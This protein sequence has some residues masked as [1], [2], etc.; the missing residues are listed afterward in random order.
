MLPQDRI[1]LPVELKLKPNYVLKKYTIVI[2]NCLGLGHVRNL[3][4]C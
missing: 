2:I 4:V 3:Y 1:K